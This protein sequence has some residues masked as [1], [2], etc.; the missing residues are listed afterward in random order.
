VTTL[1]AGTRLGR[2][3]IRSKI[4]AGGMGEVYLA[5]DTKLDRKVALKILPA[6]VAAHPDRMKRFVQEAKAASALNHP[7]IITIYEIEEWGSSPTVRE[8]LDAGSITRDET[9]FI[10]MEFIDGETLRQHMNLKHLKVAEALDLG[11]QIAS[12]LSAAHA[13]GIIHRDIKP[14]N[15]MIR[16]DGIVKV[17]DFGLAKL[18]EQAATGTVD[19]EAV[20][21]A[22]VQT[23]PGVVVGTAAY[24]SPEQARGLVVDA[25]TDIFSLGVVI[26]EMVAS[27]A[28]FGGATRSDLI[29]ALLERDPPPLARFTPE[30]PAE[31]ERL[32]MKTLAKDRE[33]RYQTAK[34]LLIDL[35]GLKQKLVVDAEIERS[36]PPEEFRAPLSG[37]RESTTK[38]GTLNGA[39]AQTAIDGIRAT[40]SAEYI[41]SKIK[42]HKRVAGLTL[43]TVAIIAAAAVFFYSRRTVPLTEK[44]TIL[45]ADFVNTTGD[46][47]F[48]GTLKQALA[49]QLEQSPFLNIF[50][51]ER[52]R[53]TLRFMNRSPNER[54][55]KD[56]AREICQRHGLKAYLSGS[57]S[58]LGSHLVITLEAVN[59][60]TGDTLASQQ[61]EAESK[62]QVLSTLGKAAT[63]LREKLGES[64]AS[65]QKY[66]APIEATT[67]SLEALKAFSLGN[68]QNHKLKHAEAILLLKRA[69]ELDPDF[70]RAYDALALDYINL[71]QRQLAIEAVQKAFELRDRT[72]EYEKLRIASDY[73]DLVTGEEEKAIEALELL[74]RTYPRDYAAHNNLTGDYYDVGRYERGI[75]EAREAVRLNPTLPSGYNLLAISFRSL[76]R[77]DEAKQICEQALAQKLDVTGYHAELYTIAFVQG[78]A[79]AMQQQLDWARGK[80]DEYEALF[81]QAETAAYLGQLRRARELNQRGVDEQLS[82]NLKENAAETISANA[83]RAAVTGN[84]QQGREGIAHASALPHT[85]V[86]FSRIGMVLALCSEI[87]QA[88]SLA[89]EYAK[90]Y[91]KHTLV[92]AVWLPAIRAAI[93]IR[94]NNPAQA[95]QFLQ[96]AT[97]Y[98]RTGVYWAQYLRGQAYLAQHAGAEAAAEFQKILDRRGLAPTSVLYPLAHLGL[99]RAAALK[100]DVAGSRKAYQDFFALWKDA[101]TD[102][103]I[104]IEAKKEYEKV[105]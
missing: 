70:A 86:S 73:Y 32:V 99:A 100:G 50:S 66:D 31:L 81:W 37:G 20:T 72:S 52:V 28:P 33:E 12:A 3:E 104:L 4:G 5:Q 44:D 85:P 62:E 43:I 84:C 94:R 67:S 69:I 91:P 57:I 77:F 63:K 76:N 55:T 27:Q 45:L 54:V 42:R 89:D 98:D 39:A 97:R 21:K 9:H 82:R 23:E 51:D 71:G 74:T 13:A 53:E 90:Q 65:I 15:V 8:G 101:D 58:N 18:S 96:S 49:I 38:A 75:E 1:A 24:M 17:L 46:A 60:Q 95:I 59:A 16:R 83:V 40:S 88:Q 79:A 19:A 22:L 6:D 61:V 14:E 47:A 56:V 48:D 30:A 7:N 11:V 92:N 25:R 64:L 2:Y 26:Y 103:P 80:P 78:D 68:E 10:A 87:S 36:A 41:V 29:V 102:I 93:E 35:R 105:K 34:D